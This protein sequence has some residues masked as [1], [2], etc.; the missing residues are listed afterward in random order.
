MQNIHRMLGILND[1]ELSQLAALCKKLGTGAR[2]R[3]TL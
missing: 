1:D 2:A 3:M